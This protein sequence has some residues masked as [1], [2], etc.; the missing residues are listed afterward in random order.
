MLMMLGPDGRLKL[1]MLKRSPAD[2]DD[3]W[4]SGRLRLRMLGQGPADAG[5][6]RARWPAEADDAQTK[7]G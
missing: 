6:A 1:M 4:A 5:D 2:A 7:P 3:A